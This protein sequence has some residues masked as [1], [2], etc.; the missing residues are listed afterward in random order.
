VRTILIA[1]L[2]VPLLASAFLYT[3]FFVWGDRLPIPQTMEELRPSVRSI[4]YDRHGV[5]IGGYYIEDRLP[6][7]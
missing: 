1:F 2:A 4:V 5:P 6:V 7:P 3:L